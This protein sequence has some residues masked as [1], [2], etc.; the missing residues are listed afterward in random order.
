MP[1]NIYI[2]TNIAIDICDIK[3][4]AHASSLK[5]IR[6]YTDSQCELYI[7][8][9]TLATLFYVLRNHA[10]FSF[11]ETLEK[12]YFIG[13]VFTLISID[14]TIFYTALELCSKKECIDYEDAVQYVCAKQVEADLI[15]TNDKKFVSVDIELQGTLNLG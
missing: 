11:E 13:E 9:D 15:V 10:K 2:D 6:K 5:T 4:P 3:R 12:M 7:N 8:S 1:T 14:E